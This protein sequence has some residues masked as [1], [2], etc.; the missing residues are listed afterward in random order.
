MTK[1]ENQGPLLNLGSS[2]KTVLCGKSRSMFTPQGVQIEQS[3]KLCRE[4]GDSERFSLQEKVR[5]ESQT[6]PYRKPTQVNWG[7]TLR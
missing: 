3:C 6:K 7:S 4:M 2:C 1:L 5:S